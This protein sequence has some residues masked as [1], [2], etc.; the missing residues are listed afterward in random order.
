M[1]SSSAP[2]SREKPTM[3]ATKIAAILRTS[4]TALGGQIARRGHLRP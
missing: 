4:L 3:S 1:R 2:A